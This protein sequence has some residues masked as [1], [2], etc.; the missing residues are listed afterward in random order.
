MVQTVSKNFGN[1][2]TSIDLVASFLNCSVTL[3]FEVR[4]SINL[5]GSNYIFI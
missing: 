2:T 4:A 5:I 1:R 3:S